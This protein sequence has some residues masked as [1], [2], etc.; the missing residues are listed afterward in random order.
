[1]KKTQEQYTVTINYQNEAGFW[2]IGHVVEITIPVK[3]IKCSHERA[4]KLVQK[5]YP[6]CQVSRVDYV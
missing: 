4:A 5:R 3:K 2:K 6:G 1:V